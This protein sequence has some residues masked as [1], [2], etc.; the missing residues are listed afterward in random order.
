MD[1]STQMNEELMRYLDG[2]MQADEKENFERMLAGSPELKTELENLQLAK[3][4]VI[5]FGLKNQVA[6]IH[7]QMMKELKNETP[8]KNITPARK[9]IRYSVAVAASV[10][11]IFAGIEGYNFYKLSPSK[12]F[13]ENYT[14]Y[15]L[16]TS[17]DANLPA[18]SPIEKAYREKNYNEVIRLNTNSV[19]SIKD[20]FL[21]GISFLETGDAAKAI[22]S[23][24]LVLVDVKSG[25][26]SIL[27]DG[28]EYYLA[29]SYLKNRDFDQAIELMA[30]VHEN[31]SQ[32][33]KAKFTRKYINQVKKLKWR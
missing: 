29:L 26:N 9:I 8:V 22:S 13:S 14:A 12:L 32:L 25:S 1:N 27:K 16:N 21:T 33:Y 5:T 19:L 31:P 2:L 30:A 3:S 17:R 18:E 23:F 24:Q 15:E 7:E 28:A 4:A 6:E 20:I 11:L 10:L